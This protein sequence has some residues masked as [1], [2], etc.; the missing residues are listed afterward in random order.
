[1]LVAVFARAAGHVVDDVGQTFVV[2]FGG[3]KGR[4]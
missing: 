4:E 2:D 1:V 3:L